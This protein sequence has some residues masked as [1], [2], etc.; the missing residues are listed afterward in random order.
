[1]IDELPM[2]RG[3]AK[4]VIGK[5]DYLTKCVEAELIK[6]ITSVKVVT[7]LP[8]TVLRIG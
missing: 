4:Y 7:T 5:V 1:M 2:A 3:R 8:S 6:D